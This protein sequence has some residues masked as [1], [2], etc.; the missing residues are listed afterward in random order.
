MTRSRL[1]LSVALLPFLAACSP[2]SESAPAGTG[3]A[4]DDGPDPLVMYAP[5]ADRADVLGTLIA[6]LQ[7]LGLIG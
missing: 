5:G 1:F 4:G 2:A 3:D 7:G 6:D